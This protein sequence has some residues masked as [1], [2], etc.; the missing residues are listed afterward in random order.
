MFWST[1]RVLSTGGVF[2]WDFSIHTIPDLLASLGN[3]VSLK[4]CHK[5]RGFGLFFETGSH[6]FALAGLETVVYSKAEES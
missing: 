4:Y 6:C 2:S 3:T 5:F 1:R